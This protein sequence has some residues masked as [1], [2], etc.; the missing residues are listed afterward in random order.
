MRILHCCLG[1]FYFDGYQYQENNLPIVNKNDGHEVYIIAS[2]EMISSDNKTLRYV[3]PRS[4][5]TEEGID[6]IRLPYKK[7]LPHSI[8]KKLRDYE[9]LYKA[10]EKIKPDVIFFHGIQ[11]YALDTIAK[12][13]K[14]HPEV[15]VF[16]DNH[17]D[18]NNSAQNFFSK[19]VLH[20]IFYR[21][22]IRRTIGAFDKIFYLSKETRK[23]LQEMYGIDDTKLEFLPLG[24]LIPDEE[25]AQ[26]NRE[27]IRTELGLTDKDI[28]LIHSGKMNELKRTDEILEIVSKCTS[29]NI[30]LILIGS[31]T[32][33][34][35][36]FTKK[37]CEKDHRIQYLG[38]RNASDLNAYLQAA[39]LYLQPGSQSITLHNAI[40]NGCAVALYPHESYVDIF[41]DH[42]R[43]VKTKDDMANL[44]DQLVS[45]PEVLLKM[46]KISLQ[47][48]EE[49]LDNRKQMQRLYDFCKTRRKDL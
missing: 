48:A 17:G 31:M 3:E 6:I 26:R 35:E 24:G 10:I 44:I 33:E 37:I 21:N 20:K 28:L 25:Q 32:S 29:E 41:S 8:M 1:N 14:E 27:R 30:R 40:C 16:V 5:K 7:Y 13:K 42:V 47:F 36:E 46:K 18:H 15:C 12:Y 22:M 9:G 23:F 45:E 39:D 34:L 2:T 43:Y 49:V 4:Y 11:A 38:W 19:E